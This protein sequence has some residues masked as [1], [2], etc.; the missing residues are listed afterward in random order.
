MS[1]IKEK[2]YLAR[3]SKA[4]GIKGE[5]K[6]HLFNQEDSCLKNGLEV[7]LKSQQGL[8]N[9]TIDSVRIGVQTII[10]F[11]NINTRNELESLLPFELYVDKESLP[12]LEANEYYYKDLIGCRVFDFE[13][14]D[15]VGDVKDFFDNGA[16]V[17]LEIQGKDQFL[18]PFVP[19]IIETFDVIKKEVFVKNVM[20]FKI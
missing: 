1:D 6:L 15:Y 3:S 18:I 16:Q 4:H 9:V 10:K 5:A 12:P 2:V 20:G 11:K 14:T 13:N 8:R 17:I 7:I 19:Q